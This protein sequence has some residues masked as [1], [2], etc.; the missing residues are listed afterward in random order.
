MRHLLPTL[1]IS[2]VISSCLVGGTLL[3]RDP[4]LRF[5]IIAA[6]DRSPE[7]PLRAGVVSVSNG[8]PFTT[9]SEGGDYNCGA[10]LQLYPSFSP[11]PMLHFTGKTGAAKG[12]APSG[13][14]LNL[15]NAIWGTTRRGGAN[16]GG[17]VYRWDPATNLFTTVL[18][19][20]SRNAGDIDYL[21]LTPKAGLVQ[22]GHGILWGT[23]S[24]VPGCIFKLNPNTRSSIAVVVANGPSGSNLG[25]DLRGE[26]V[27][28][29]VD[30]LW[31]VSSDGG[32]F[33]HGLIF[34]VHQDTGVLTIVQSFTGAQG[35]TIGSKPTGALLNDGNGFL[36]GLT[37][38]IGTLT[39]AGRVFKIKISTGALTNVSLI[40]TTNEGSFCTEGLVVTGTDRLAGFIQSAHTGVNPSYGA[41]FTISTVSGPAAISAT[42]SN[43]ATQASGSMMLSR[44]NN[45]S[46]I[47]MAASGGTNDKG[48]TF[49]VSTAGTVSNI[50][51]LGGTSDGERTTGTLPSGGLIQG[52]D[53][54]LWG[55]LHSGGTNGTGTIY[56]FL[57]SNDVLNYT[58]FSNNQAIAH[59]VGELVTTK[60]G[61]SAGNIWGLS[62]AGGRAGTFL[63]QDRGTL[64]SLYETAGYNVLHPTRVADFDAKQT[65]PKAGLCLGPDDRL[66]GASGQSIYAFDVLNDSFRRPIT[67]TGIAG[68]AP[69]SEPSSALM[70]DGARFM[71]GCTR[72][73]GANDCG[74]L[75]KVDMASHEFT[76]VVE[77][78]GIDSY[79]RGREPNG[80][81]LKDTNGRF[82]GVTKFG[83]RYDQGT[84]FFV[85]GDSGAVTTVMDFDSAPR[86]LNG[87]Q[88]AAGLVSD[89][90][91]WLWG[92]TSKGGA[93]DFGTIFRIDP[94]TRIFE[95]MFAFTGPAV[96]VPGSS[97][98]AR[99]FLHSDGNLYGTTTGA[100]LDAAGH[101]KSGGSI[102]RIRF[103]RHLITATGDHDS[104]EDGVPLDF[105]DV[106]D[107]EDQMIHTVVAKN[108]LGFTFR[109]LN[110]TI[111]GPNAADFRVTNPQPPSLAPNSMQVIEITFDPSGTGPRNATLTL[112]G[113]SPLDDLF[114]IPLTGNGLKREAWMEGFSSLMENSGSVGY[115]VRISKPLFSPVRI[116]LIVRP[117]S[118][119][120]ADYKVSASSVTIP[121]H[122]DYAFFTITPKDDYLIEG[123]ESF[124]IDLGTPSNVNVQ[125]AD[126][127][128]PNRSSHRSITIN[129]DDFL[130]DIFGP[131]DQVVQLGDTVEIDGQYQASSI[132][133][134]GSWK[135]NG[136]L[137][138]GATKSILTWSKA[139]TAHAGTYQ[140]SVKTV[141]GLT[142]SGPLSEIA[143]I[144]QR[145]HR[146]SLGV[147]TT[148]QLSFVAAGNELA[149]SW[150]RFDSGTSAETP[151]T[152][153][154][155][156]SGTTTQAL[157]ITNLG[158][159]DSGSYRCNVT[160]RGNALPAPIEFT[161]SAHSIA[162]QPLAPKFPAAM[163]Q[164]PFE[165]QL[166]FGGGDAAAPSTF[167]VTGLPAGLTCNP[168]T[169]LITG[170]P[171][172]PGTS[173]LRITMTNSK[174]S[175]I[176]SAPLTV[177]SMP[178]A[179]LGHFIGNLGGVYV[180][181]IV[182]SLGNAT[183][184][185][186]DAG[187]TY[188]F[189]AV[190]QP[191]GPGLTTGHMDAIV[192][193]LNGLINPALSVI[194]GKDISGD[195]YFWGGVWPFGF[196]GNGWHQVWSPSKPL[197]VEAQGYYTLSAREAGS[198]SSF[199]G[200]LG[201][202]PGSLTIQASGTSTFVA[203]LA[204][205]STLTHASF[206]GPQLEFLIYQG[207]YSYPGHFIAQGAITVKTPPLR[208]TLSANGDWYRPPSATR[209]RS[210]QDGFGPSIELSGSRYVRP[211]A[212]QL[213]LNYAAPPDNAQF[214]FG[215]TIFGVLDN[216]PD[217]QFSL[218]TTHQ[219]TLP[220]L[221]S[222][223][224]PGR[225][226][227][228][229]IDPVTG[230]FSGKFTLDYGTSL[231]RSASFTGVIDQ[232]QD[233]GLGYF[234][235]ASLADNLADPPTT[236]SNSPMVS[237]WVIL[238][239]PGANP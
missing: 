96:G 90:R 119:S 105:G 151:L 107:V 82:W 150:A 97:P 27:F 143:V 219:A 156:Y 237:G 233:I 76:S 125:L 91:G 205:G 135:R 214:T 204:D 215:T 187:K 132:P 128:S 228:V 146:L 109:P 217:V 164:L 78:A 46:V 147:G 48:A 192:K 203:R 181:F 138:P 227:S 54:T 208:S 92:T 174:G 2:C 23:T 59:P 110:I 53:G 45:A 167:T 16:D 22:D 4:N 238:S 127:S 36:W 199:P 229:V 29:G 10:I 231:A 196:S 26:L 122:Q 28:D 50:Q 35:S 221:G 61:D 173:S 56:K 179:L 136:N 5:E 223:G 166:P 123:D 43:A 31:G 81:L 225:V 210:F 120:N 188:P 14:L 137:I 207:L 17:T 161:L 149:F 71:W 47:G 3:A 41:I 124:T 195:H 103:G 220:A 171:I 12:D 154:G 75:Y 77:F 104:H 213:A 72:R 58:S 165:Y 63:D 30:S 7:H 100:G 87:A 226:T 200:Y 44:L 24:S 65:T 212:G 168:S 141:T 93:S 64:F 216:P 112:S 182:T 185:I 34:K 142:V 40:P 176:V 62:E 89:G 175:G 224:N 129:D 80:T 99:L 98:E 33:G 202:S 106:Y 67:L 20:G 85:D 180:D 102:F 169:G 69:G 193:D 222:T 152:D 101:L 178:P 86:S 218:S 118:A 73:G 94:L 131:G 232:S 177:A 201:H 235:I 21:G 211:D 115:T 140:F 117:G 57:P 239:A 144:D 191:D 189:I 37:S 157:R 234:L 8:G 209:T 83:G 153:D 68:V 121:A 155:K 19:F 74:T 60:V 230:N 1:V 95:T 18:E 162:P 32:T 88:P 6:F 116:P 55:C 197:P 194:V 39:D 126:S 148:A 160:F 190:M 113:D 108:V 79:P 130:P 206:V 51:P 163:V 38:P 186:R 42:F 25:N 172:M 49:Q 236:L 11:Q 114:V 9:A 159:P 183:G 133:A 52:A 145:P 111:S 198:T 134:T 13:A 170:T 84:L 184:M 66:W 158:A 15:N 139:T 70:F